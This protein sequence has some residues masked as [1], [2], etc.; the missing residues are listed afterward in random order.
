[1]PWCLSIAH[2][3]RAA[4]AAVSCDPATMVGIDLVRPEVLRPSF[5]ETWFT[6]SERQW[7]AAEQVERVAACWG[8][9]EAVYKARQ[10]GEGFAP[11]QIEIGLRDPRRIAPSPACLSDEPLDAFAE[12]L[13]VRYRGIDLKRNVRVACRRLAGHIA[14]AVTLKTT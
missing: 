6:A 8:V 12:R 13:A 2:T 11:R 3:D 9:K 10:R 5:L 4:L 14:V 1:V 7:L